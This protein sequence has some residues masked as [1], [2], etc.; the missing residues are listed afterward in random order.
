VSTTT[1]PVTMI[2]DSTITNVPSPFVRPPFYI[3]D[4]VSE[5][6]YE[7]APGLTR[8]AGELIAEYPDLADCRGFKIDVLWKHKG[9][10]DLGKC[11]KVGDLARHYAEADYIVWLAIDNVREQALSDQQITALLFHELMHVEE[12]LDRV[13]AAAQ[14]VHGHHLPQRRSRLLRRRGGGWQVHLAGQPHGL[15]AIEYPGSQHLILRRKTKELRSLMREFRRWFPK[16]MAT[17]NLN[18][19]EFTFTLAA[20][21]PPHPRTQHRALRPSLHRDENVADYYSEEFDSINWDEASTSRA[22]CAPR[23]KSAC[24]PPTAAATG[25]RCAT[26]PTPATSGTTT[27]SAS[28]CARP[29]ATW[30]CSG[31]GTPAKPATCSTARPSRAPGCPSRLASAARRS[32]HRV[33]PERDE[34]FE[35]INAQ[36]ELLGIEPLPGMPTRCYI[37]SVIQDNRFLFNDPAYLAGLMTLPKKRLRAMVGGDW[38]AIEGQYFEA[39][40]PKLHVIPASY[41]PAPGATCWRSLDWGQQAPLACYWHTYDQHLTM[42]LTYRELYQARLS[43]R[44]ACALIQEMTPAS[45]RIFGT[46]AD[47]SMW[48]GARHEETQSHAEAYEEYGV[49]LLKANNSR[50]FGWNKLREV[51]ELN[52]ETGHPHWA[53][54]ADCVN[55]IRTLPTLIASEKDPEIVDDDGE[56]HAGD[57]LRYGLVAEPSLIYRRGGTG[58]I[59]AEQPDDDPFGLPPMYD[60]R[61]MLA[62]MLR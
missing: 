31:T 8:I 18:R 34:Q 39:F 47:P 58:I 48:I 42:V 43:D 60:S 37:P 50:R 41:V 12:V 36:R 23:W 10:K 45:E 30:N 53:I 38:D 21:H 26:A 11:V 20:G 3:P 62:S 29:T 32:L 40:D 52:R 33:A 46:Y 56:D 15:Q 7:A 25:C 5:T 9:G 2:I 6:G 54:T 17:L 16:E 4:P 51:L 57:A 13:C 55:A 61:E 49:P 44:E 14:A 24:V 35:Q 59:V 1:T 27:S 22:S 28:S 19:M